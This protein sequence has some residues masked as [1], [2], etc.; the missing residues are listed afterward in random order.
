MSQ[1]DA[2]ALLALTLGA[3]L[4]PLLAER[5]GWFSAPCEMIY[6]IV[7]ANLLPQLRFN[8]QFISTLSEFGFLL[9]L[10]LAGLEIDFDMLRRQGA[11]ALLTSAL[12]ALGIQAGGLWLTLLLHLPVIYALLIGAISVTVL[13]AILHESG[14]LHHPLGQRLLIIGAL[15][16]FLSIIA[17]T[18]YDLIYSYGLDWQLAIAAGKL[19]A[20]LILGY[21]GLRGLIAVANTRSRT[22]RR[23]FALRDTSELGVRAALALMLCFAAAAL[24][25]RVE[26]I[27]ATFIA[28]A[29]SSFAFRG[30]NLVT[31]KLT[32]MGQG[33]FLPIFFI[34]VGTQVRLLDL[35]SPSALSLLIAVTVGLIGVR[36]AAIPLL[37]LAGVQLRQALTAALMLSAPL[38]LMVAI[39]QV[40]VRLGALNSATASAALGASI[41]S[42][43]LFPLLARP[44]L[45]HEARAGRPITIGS[46]QPLPQP[47]EFPAAER[48]EPDEAT[49]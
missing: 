27:L 28:G 29:I 26:A 25:L 5:I 38:S 40:G 36:L 14:M 43:T 20:L 7:V 17:V 24:I 12:A 30:R 31:E 10:F 41:V 32:T 19:I 49:A 35:L 13:M 45:L 39:A 37:R 3:F 16:E 8:G 15:G 33:F 11:R 4:M 48:F 46:T 9:L 2:L 47:V 34:T 22:V 21:V 44:F 1:S 6:G 18:A 42:A 23:L